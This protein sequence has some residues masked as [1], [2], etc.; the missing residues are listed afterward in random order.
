MNTTSNKTMTREFEICEKNLESDYKSET[1]LENKTDTESNDNET[2]DDDGNETD[3]DE[4]DNERDVAKNCKNI[5][6]L[7]KHMNNNYEYYNSCDDL[8]SIKF[9]ED[10]ENNTFFKKR[11]IFNENITIFEHEV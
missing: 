10:C 3:D 1:R 5:S 2:D 7:K 11:V 9:E 8:V 4:D 6:I